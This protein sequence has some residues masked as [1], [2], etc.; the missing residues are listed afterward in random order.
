M[1]TGARGPWVSDAVWEQVAG[2]GEPGREERRAFRVGVGAVLVTLLG[3]VLLWGSG[4]A[5]PVLD[6][7][8]SSGG[9]SNPTTR[10]VVYEFDLGNRGL[11]PAT[12]VGASTAVPGVTVVATP[13]RFRL[14]PGESQHLRLTV[15]VHDCAA[16]TQSVTAQLFDDPPVDITVSRPWGDVTGHVQ[17][18]GG[19]WLEDLLP[20]AC[21][22]A[23]TG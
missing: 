3:A 6:P 13:G 22:L 19:S 11:M 14:A 5:S 15:T 8:N 16:A 18:P 10:T 7:G 2:Q 20:S 17:P 21:G 23:P 1:V 4:L 9:S 12:V